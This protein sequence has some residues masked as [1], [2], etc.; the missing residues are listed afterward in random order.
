MVSLL[1]WARRTS[2]SEWPF[3]SICCMHRILAL[4]CRRGGNEVDS[5]YD[6]NYAFLMR[7]WWRHL[8]RKICKVRVNCCDCP[9]GTSSKKDI[10][11][12]RDGRKLLNARAILICSV[13][14]SI[15]HRFTYIF[16]VSIP[17][18]YS[19]AKRKQR[20]TSQHMRRRDKPRAQTQAKG[21]QCKPRAKIGRGKQVVCFTRVF[22]HSRS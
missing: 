20:Q 9:D 13:H 19:K 7:K 4:L 17:I 14:H 16:I 10:K 1:R 12:T 18:L 21:Q 5:T 3:C 6:R 22:L 2:L 15:F 11:T 8:R